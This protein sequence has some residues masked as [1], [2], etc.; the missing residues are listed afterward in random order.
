MVAQPLVD[1]GQVVDRLEAVGLGPHRLLIQRPRVLQ[2]ALEE[3]AVAL[4]DQGLCVVPV[5][6]HR[7]VGVLDRVAKVALV[8]V[9]E[10]QRL[11]RLVKLT[12][13]HEVQ[14]FAY[15]HLG[16]QLVLPGG[17]ERLGHPLVPRHHVSV[18]RVDEQL[19]GGGEILVRRA[20]P[21]AQRGLHP[22]ILRDVGRVHRLQLVG[23][24]LNLPHRQKLGKAAPLPLA[25]AERIIAEHQVEA[26]VHIGR[27]LH[28]LLDLGLDLF[29][30]GGDLVERHAVHFDRGGILALLVVDVAHVDPQ[31]TRL[32][33]LLVLDDERVGV[34]RLAVEPVCV[35]LVGQ[36]ETDRVGQINVDLLGQPVLLALLAEMA[37]ALARFLRLIKCSQRLLLRRQL[38]RLLDELVHLLLNLTAHVLGR[39]VTLLGERRCGAARRGATLPRRIKDSSRRL[40]LPGRGIAR[41][42]HS[43]HGAVLLHRLRAARARHKPR[44]RAGGQAG[45]AHRRARRSATSA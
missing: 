12:R 6:P 19:R 33:V 1:R 4:V 38:R 14:G 36:V 45:A 26:R 10:G 31:P 17:R 20:D 3:E 13:P 8:K 9:D 32:R 42:A 24:H 29:S 41:G 16:G 2:L 11:D 30:C 40:L 7:E 37:L 44:A 34:E 5:M 21:L 22:V 15:G 35:V 18:D 23:V 39:V 27:R 25:V 28:N 43:G